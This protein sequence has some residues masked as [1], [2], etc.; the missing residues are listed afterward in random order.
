[1][2]CH[3]HDHSE[4][5]CPSPSSCA[6]QPKTVAPLHQARPTTVLLVS[7][8]FGLVVFIGLW[9]LPKMDDS[10]HQNDLDTQESGVI[11]W[12]R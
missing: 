2:I 12:K 4:C 10:Y 7:I 6:V 1:M 5:L 9:S 11:A 3:F 8:A